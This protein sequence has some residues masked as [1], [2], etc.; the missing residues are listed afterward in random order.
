LAGATEAFARRH[1]FGSLTRVVAEIARPRYIDLCQGDV[2]S[3]DAGAGLDD[4]AT[5]HLAC[6]AG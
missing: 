5:I 1:R 4:E 2:A 3:L 6:T